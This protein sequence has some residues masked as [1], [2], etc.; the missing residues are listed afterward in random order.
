MIYL[1]LSEEIT[2]FLAVLYTLVVYFDQLSGAARTQKLIK[3]FFSAVFQPFLFIS[4]L[5]QCYIK[6]QVNSEFNKTLAVNIA[7]VFKVLVISADPV[8]W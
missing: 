3:T 2:N 1:V 6:P 8:I 5:F 4:K 7:L